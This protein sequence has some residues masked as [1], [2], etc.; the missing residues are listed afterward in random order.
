MNLYELMADYV[1]STGAATAPDMATPELGHALSLFHLSLVESGAAWEGTE[2]KPKITV[3]PTDLDV[4]HM[5]HFIVAFLPFHSV[6]RMSEVNEI[7][8]DVYLF[9]KWLEKRDITHGLESVDVMALFKDLCTRQ[10]RCLKLS[11]LLDEESGHTLEDPPEIHDTLND[12][13]TV[14]KIGEDLVVLKGQQ[15]QDVIRLRLPRHILPLI[16]LN[17]CLDLVLGDTSERWVLLEAG[18]VYPT[19]SDNLRSS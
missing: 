10:E 6:I 13:F 9:L 5:S 19:P 15:Q 2:R 17:D 18:K 8:F 7:L 14:D 4:R 12:V 11:Q 16:E 3:P 1:R